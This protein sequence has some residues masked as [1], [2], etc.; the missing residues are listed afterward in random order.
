MLRPV[1]LSIGSP[2]LL[3]AH[4]YHYPFR[5]ERGEVELAGSRPYPGA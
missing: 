2:E 5:R 1:L 4:L 3:A